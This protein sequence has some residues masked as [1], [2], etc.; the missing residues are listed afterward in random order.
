MTK[1]YPGPLGGG[2]SSLKKPG[3]PGRGTAVREESKR[4]LEKLRTE[5]EKLR[6]ELEAERARGRAERRRF[7]AQARQLREADERER[8]QMV[9]QLRS[10]W[11]AQR[12]RE[13][14]Q[15]RDNVLREREAEIRQLLRW[16]EAELRQLYQL[17]RRERDGVVR[18]ARELQRQLAEELM[19]RGYCGRAGATDLAT[20]HCSCRLQDVLAQLRWETDGEQA[21]RIRHL[22][23]TLDVER[24]LFLKYILEHFRWR[25]TLPEPRSPQTEPASENPPPETASRHSEP[26]CPGGLLHRQI[27]GI[28][29]RSRSLD[30]E[31]L[32]VR[33]TSRDGQ[34]PTRASSLDSLGTARSRSLYSSRSRPQTTEPEELASSTNASIPGSSPPPP[35][36]PSPQPSLLPPSEHQKTSDPRSGEVSGRPC[37]A[38]TTSPSGLD[39]PELVK[40]NTELTEALRVLDRRCFALREENSQ[41]RHAGFPDQAE[42]KVQLLKMKNAELTGLAR[43]LEDR[44][45]KLQE[46]NLRALSAPIPGESRADTELCQAFVSQSARELT[47]QA[48]A[49]VAKDRQI[50]ELQQKCHLL[51]VHVAAGLGIAPLPVRGASGGALEL[52]TG[53]L[54]R[55]LRESQREVLR[56]QRQLMVQ[57]SQS[58]SRAKAGSQSALREEA[59]RRQVQELERELDAGRRQCQELDSQAAAVQRRGE[60]AE[61]QLQAALR[62]GVWLA[63]DNARLQA[64][65]NW[66]RKVE[67]EK[68]DVLGQLGHACQEHDTA[69]LLAEKLFQQTAR[70]QDRQLQ[71][72]DLQK[73][74]PDLQAA[75]EIM[76]TLQCQS[77]EVTQVPKSQAGDNRR[78]KFQ[79]GL[80]DQALP[81]PNKDTQKTETSLSKSPVV[82]GEPASVPQVPTRAPADEL[83]DCRLQAKKA[84]S[85]SFSEM[86]SV[87]ATVPFCP[88]LSLDTASEVDDLEPDSVFPTLDIG[89]LEAH[90]T[91]KLKVFLARYSYNP[92]EGPNEHPE[93]ELSLTAGDY[94]YIFG[95][96]DEDGFYKGELED[97]RQGLVPSNLVEPV[98]DNDILRCPSLKSPKCDSVSHLDTA[99]QEDTHLSLS[100]GK[101]QAAVDRGSYPVVSVVSKTK[102]AVGILD[103]DMEASQ[104]DL[105]HSLGEQGCSRAL[106]G[107][108]WPFCVTPT[109]LGFQSITATSVK[110]TWVSKDSI[111][112]HIVYLDDQEQALT[113]AGVSCYT[114]HGLRPATEYQARVEVRLPPHLLQV[115]CNK[116]SSTITFATPL[117][118]PPDPPLDVL[119]E[120][121][122]SPGLLVVSWLPVT[123]DSA[124][125][126]NGV[127]VTGYAVYT[128]GLKV[129]EVANATAGSTLL[130]FSQLQVPSLCQKVSVRTMSLCGESLDSVPAQI[131]ED[132]FTCHRL[133]E[134]SP[135]GCTHGDLSTC[136]V[137][138]PL[139]PWKLMLAPL[140]SKTSSHTPE[141]CGELQVELPEAFSE[142]SSKRWSPV[143][144]L[145]SEGAC[146]SSGA[147]SQA[148]G[149]REAWEDSGKDLLFQKSL[150]EQKS[151]LPSDQS[152]GQE[153]HYHDMGTSKSPS[154]EL[155]HLSAEYGPSK[156]LG[157][158]KPPLEKVLRQ[159][160]VA[161]VSS[162]VQW[163]PN[164]QYMSG[165]PKLLASEKEVCLHM[166]GT[167]Q[168]EEREALSAQ[169]KHGQTLAGKSEH[170]VHEPSSV[171]CPAQSSKDI[172]MSWVDPTCLRQGVDSPA[173][174][175]VA[176]FD[177]DPLVMSVNPHS[178]E[179]KLAFQKGQLLKVW[180]SQD[181]NGFYHGECSGQVVTIP[182]HLVAEAEWTDE[183][184]PLLAQEHLHSVTCLDNF[185]G[186]TG[187]QSSFPMAQGKPRSPP[188]WTSKTMMATLDY[189]PRDRRG[190]DRVKDKLVLRAGDMVTIYGS[191]DDQGFY[192]GE[193]GGH[194][195]LVPAHLLDYMSFHAHTKGVKLQLG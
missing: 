94:V 153:N 71:Q 69:D 177:Y 23:E 170:Q 68:N 59:G 22:Q 192:Y 123:I 168:Q 190:G 179:E 165:C 121:H 167:E 187:H 54:E 171:L 129:A 176:L 26:A 18:Q 148:Q 186:L 86:E 127:Q 51:Q 139:C 137:T 130:D 41:L 13:L 108:R 82:L 134:T 180:G 64:Q 154:P 175:F 27:T 53:D 36:P 25:P 109:Q 48:S 79:P 1:D 125:S 17:L 161:Q 103:A 173:R 19:N 62:E 193:S 75:L 117:A 11:E 73:A 52:S 4:E 15:L 58:S 156:V 35:S 12:G 147:G 93:G 141:S 107:G 159:K 101:A 115:H 184:C 90:A 181:P 89:G 155:A 91:T 77:H 81:Q 50:E 172:N 42:K 95:D 128:D 96:M 122:S 158:Y 110:I 21:A 46:T 118:G 16:K 152:S 111:H 40:R 24:Q 104:L 105:L 119:V 78:S 43:R 34:L 6:A 33:S 5:L 80:E 56:L 194:W 92:F 140:S 126:S 150:Q 157:W 132:C 174:V 65:T 189:D 37:E 102:V 20:A 100:P 98:L 63:E 66:G 55:L 14:R 45:R 67:A 99:L 106:L 112:P 142:E 3:S 2:R 178:A 70:G 183:R 182:G 8:Q 151:S 44:A 32:P 136:R 163:G 9:D 31:V 88:N 166:W 188:L 114:F 124:G 84:S 29:M 83:P 144:S 116:M 146:L 169:N 195:G 76:Q 57:Q 160:Q 135:F 60:E 87:W 131:P 143:T 185:G 113:P 138:F 85:N 10:R 39:Y 149:P 74:L 28:H 120:R 30:W 38:L 7:V 162:P 145:G 49:L 61:V 72:Q 97:G 47:E 164:Q 133:L 191:V